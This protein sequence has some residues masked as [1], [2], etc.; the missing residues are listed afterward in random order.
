VGVIDEQN[1][2]PLVRR[3][4]QQRQRRGADRERRG[5]DRRAQVEHA[6]EQARLPFLE[7]V[8]PLAQRP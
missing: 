1:R 4:R 6:P 2:R 8:E 3:D 5:P 7:L